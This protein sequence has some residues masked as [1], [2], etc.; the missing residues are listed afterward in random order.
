MVDL[1]SG[2]AVPARSFVSQFDSS[3]W[4]LLGFCNNLQ[5]HRHTLFL[6]GLKGLVQWQ[7][8]PGRRNGGPL[9]PGRPGE[10]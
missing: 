3:P 8:L 10:Q 5:R 1:G 9:L 4:G 6:A 7:M 2:W